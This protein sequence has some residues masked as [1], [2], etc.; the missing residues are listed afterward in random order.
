MIMRYIKFTLYLLTL[1]T[2][3]SVTCHTYVDILEVSDSVLE[4]L[5]LDGD[6]AER[7][8]QVISARCDGG[9]R[10]RRDVSADVTGTTARR[11]PASW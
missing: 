9:G 7:R 5:H 3:D 11:Q 2:Y 4:A 6:L 8:R 10:G 1:L